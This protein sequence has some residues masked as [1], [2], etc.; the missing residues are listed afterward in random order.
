MP[1]ASSLSTHNDPGV[2]IGET[3]GEI[4]EVIGPAPDAV[5]VFI[6]GDF[7]I[8]AKDFLAA[9]HQLLQ[10]KTLVGT[11]AVS[12]IAGSRE[13]EEQSA[14]AVW[15]GK[16]AGT[17]STIRLEARQAPDGVIKIDEL[18]NAEAHTLILLADPFSFPAE[19]AVDAWSTS[20]PDLQII[21]GLAS[22][23]NTPNGNRFLLDDQIFD[24]GAVGLLIGGA[25]Q[26]EP[27]VS[28]GCRPVGLPLIV[29]AAEGNLIQELGGKPALRRLEEM[30]NGLNENERLLVNQ[31]LHIGRVIDEHKVE[32]GT[33]DFLIR[34]V[35]GADQRTGSLAIGDNAPVGSTVQ[36][37]VRDAESADEDLRLLVEP[38]DSADGAL[39]FTC[40]GRGSHLFEHPDHDAAIIADLV[41]R[42]AV[43]GMFCAGEIGPVGEHSFLH[44]F[45]AS[46]AIFRD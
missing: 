3:I 27:L 31:G 8:H 21:G 23:A 38:I 46:A 39:V 44:G 12:V 19:L 24:A 11:T 42:E 20:R 37:Q 14:V 45:T 30:F 4:L 18:S 40:N 5:V 26:V 36:F 15:A 29:T 13:V 17:V 1:Y 22:G 32:F 10:P 6:S 7:I 9:T 28:Q 16:F 2:A 41:R 33:G 43:A 35:L 34:A 25:T